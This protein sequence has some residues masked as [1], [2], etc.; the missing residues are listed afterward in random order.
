MK[1]ALPTGILDPEEAPWWRFTCDDHEPVIKQWMGEA[2]VVFAASL[3]ARNAGGEITNL[4]CEF[5][6]LDGLSGT[7]TLNLSEHKNKEFV[8]V[9]TRDPE[10]TIIPITTV[11][12]PDANG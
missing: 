3:A 10:P 8:L 11:V 7:Y 5:L 4:H 2:A 1:T 12:E 6:T 9:I